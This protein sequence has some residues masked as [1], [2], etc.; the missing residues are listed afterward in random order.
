MKKHQK[1]R[2]FKCV[3]NNFETYEEYRLRVHFWLDQLLDEEIRFARLAGRRKF[4]V[5][6]VISSWKGDND[7]S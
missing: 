1:S 4:K 7:R 5:V 2:A 3:K 6:G